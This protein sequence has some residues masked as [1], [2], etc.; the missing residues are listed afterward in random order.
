MRRMFRY[1]A[2]DRKPGVGYLLQVPDKLDKQGIKIIAMC[3]E[4]TGVI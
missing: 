2:L 1:V 3:E 4:Q